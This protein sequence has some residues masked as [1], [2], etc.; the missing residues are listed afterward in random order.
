MMKLM[1]IDVI[2]PINNDV[3]VRFTLLIA[4]CV[5]LVAL[6]LTMPLFSVCIVL[7][8]FLAIW[9]LPKP[10]SNPKHVLVKFYWICNPLFQ[11]E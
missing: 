3:S 1:I 6:D 4:Y 8:P 10:V 7:L 2:D 9:K 5:H 11:S